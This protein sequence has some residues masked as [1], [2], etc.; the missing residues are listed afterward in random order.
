MQLNKFWTDKKVLITGNTGFKG[1]WLSLWLHQMGAN[2]IGISLKQKSKNSFFNITNIDKVIPTHYID[3]N[4]F[5]M[6]FSA[7]HEFK[8]EIIFHLAAQPLV[9]ESI[10]DPLYTFNTNIIGTANILECIR[11]LNI[12]TSIIC[13][14]D[15]CY[16]NNDLNRPFNEDDRLGGKDPY[17]TSKAGAE[18]IINS[19]IKTYF[20]KLG[21]PNIASVRAGNVIGGG[22]C[23]KNRIIPDIIN[24][25]K[26]EKSIVLRSPSATRPW[27]YVLDPLYGYI[28][29]VEKLNDS[30]ESQGPWNFGPNDNS[31]EISVEQLAR[32]FLTKWGY[33]NIKIEKSKNSIKESKYLKISSEKS[34]YYLG[35]TQKV[36]IYSAI[37]KIIAWEKAIETNH[38]MLDFANNEIKIYMEQLNK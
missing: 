23:S 11:I 15:K 9:I 19:Y 36:D 2:V 18:L 35:W 4:E 29:L 28:K 13:T 30:E 34:N 10:N 22:D 5:Q 24:A 31:N 8:P 26:T 27:Q 37:S 6:L 38:N 12:K 33:K 16:E 1:G 17:S 14:S 21:S 7:I 20:Y 25:L 32:L 3:I